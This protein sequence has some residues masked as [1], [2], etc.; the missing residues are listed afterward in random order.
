MEIRSASQVNKAVLGE[1]YNSKNE[2]FVGECAT[3]N[4]VFVG[5]PESTVI[6]TRSM[7]ESEVFD[8]LGFS[9]GGSARFGVVSSS[10][11]A[12]FAS[13]ASAN[14]FSEVTIYSSQYRFKNKKLTF[15]DLTE[16][17]KQ[18]KGFSTGPFLGEKWELTCGH[19]YVEQITLGAAI[20]IS[21]KIEFSSKA[22]KEKFNSEFQV[23]GQAFSA[24]GEFEKASKSFGNSAFIIIQ[25]YQM[26]GDVSRV[27]S[28]FGSGESASNVSPDGKRIHAL[29]ACS[30]SNPGACLQI[31][32]NAIEYAT[33]TV[34]PAA[35]PQQIRPQ[36]DISDP[37]G[38]AE[39]SYI[40]SPWSDLALFP[41]PPIINDLIKAARE[42]LSNEFEKNFTLRNRI[43]ALKTSP[44]R[45]SARQRKNVEI[46]DKEITFNLK[47]I[48][49]AA[50]VCYTTI[51]RS[52]EIV[53]EIKQKLKT[54]DEENLNILP[55]S[56]AQW[57]D[58]KDLPSTKK[59]TQRTIDLLFEQVKQKVVNFD[60]I[61]DV[62]EKALTVE[63][64]V[65]TF[66]QLYLVSDL[67]LDLE[68]L[69]SLTNISTLM[70]SSN[71]ISLEPLVSLTNI[72]TLMISSSN[73]SLDPLAN[74][75]NL[76]NIGISS[77]SIELEP[78]STLVN[79]QEISISCNNNLDLKPLANLKNLKKIGISSNNIELEPLSTLINI[80]EISISCNSTID[81]SF[82]SNLSKI[83]YLSFSQSFGGVD[84]N[85]DN[86]DS[87]Q[88][89]SEIQFLR[90]ERCKISD[91]SALSKLIKLEQIDLRYN[92]ISDISP[93][94]KLLNLTKIELFDN[95][96]K[97]ISPLSLLG[98]LSELNLYSNQISDISPLSKLLNLRKLIL[99]DNQISDATD[100]ALLVNLTLLDLGKNQI[101]NVDYLSTLIKLTRLNLRENPIINKTCPIPSPDPRKPVCIF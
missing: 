32:T 89:L 5:V 67:E 43:R 15:T 9:I 63:R 19:E 50:V 42:E 49:E 24:S 90:F 31:L 101:T 4:V 60:S 41:A 2:D 82:L 1:G 70:I 22:D 85:I 26:G 86:F 37:T 13:E 99:F 92:Q 7:S 91:I 44:L 40:T 51:D 38:P 11:S 57:C 59:S 56:I 47:L 20:Y 79:I 88:S 80:Q 97:D 62:K 76:K 21:A 28:I 14:D 29:L 16:V 68:P 36:S 66:T 55:E 33:D 45:L 65:L 72:S 12:K 10:L 25:A 95:Q 64:T 58:I 17:G 81:L 3:G 35:F 78:L 96:I 27:S 87:L 23:K 52:S 74:L 6:F 18:A 75:K 69:A 98:G 53:L 93:L 61:K 54:I 94:S 39:L 71:N 30:M 46:I 34:N 48:N 77:N 8:S 100:L 84:L 83:Q 73:I